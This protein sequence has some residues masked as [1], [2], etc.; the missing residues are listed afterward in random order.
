MLQVHGDVEL[1]LP[2]IAH[3]LRGAGGER[4]PYAEEHADA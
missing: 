1:L 4:E 3:R 2:G